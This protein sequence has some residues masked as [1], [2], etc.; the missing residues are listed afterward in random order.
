M[1][2]GR[3]QVFENYMSG[4]MN[5]TQVSFLDDFT[6]MRTCGE[7]YQKARGKVNSSETAPIF[8]RM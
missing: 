1:A 5:H 6:S 8:I 7:K 3:Q 2:T 4:P